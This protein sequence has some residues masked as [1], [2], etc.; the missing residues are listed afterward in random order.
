MSKNV[1]QGDEKK[2]SAE[3][4]KKALTEQP[5]WKPTQEERREFDRI[6]F[7]E[8]QSRNSNFDLTGDLRR[9]I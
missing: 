6:R 2:L 4:L 9:F 8:E 1:K 3:E 7:A 5:W